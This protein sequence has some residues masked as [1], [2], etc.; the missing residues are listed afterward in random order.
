MSPLVRMLWLFLAGAATIAAWPAVRGSV[1]VRAGVPG[2]AAGRPRAE[3]YTQS[4]GTP[5][6]GGLNWAPPTGTLAGAGDT[7]AGGPVAAAAALPGLVA[8]ARTR[9]DRFTNGRH[10]S[11]LAARFVLPGPARG[12]GTSGSHLPG[13]GLPPVQLG[14][15]PNLPVRPGAPAA[16]SGSAGSG[17]NANAQAGAVPGGRSGTVAGSGGG[18]RRGQSYARRLSRSHPLPL[19]GSFTATSLADCWADPS[20][21]PTSIPFLAGRYRDALRIF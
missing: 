14:G 1:T 19:W 8:G 18:L 3:V 7:V 10:G 12:P 6:R 9:A 16:G 13:A 5:V 20:S 15:S 17:T 2:L 21:S 4:L 11:F